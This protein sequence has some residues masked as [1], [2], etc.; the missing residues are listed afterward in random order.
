[1]L[2]CVERHLDDHLLHLMLLLRTL[3]DTVLHVGCVKRDSGKTAA[4][5]GTKLHHMVH[6]V[7]RGVLHCVQWQCALW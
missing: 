3:Q 1:M 5:S 4:G 6:T 7:S 2:Q